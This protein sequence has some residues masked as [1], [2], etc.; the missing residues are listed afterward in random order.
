M[1]NNKI[2]DCITFFDNKLMFDLRF[3]ILKDHVDF[4]VVCE[5]KYDHRNNSKKLNFDLKFLKNNKVKYVVLDKPFPNENDIWKNQAIQREFL[6]NSLDS[7]VRENDFVF[8]SDPDEIPNPSLLINFNLKKKYGI[9]FQDCFNFKFNLYNPYETPW[10]GTRV[11]Q[12]KKPKV[13]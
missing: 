11:S 6:F 9:F 10:E 8:F 13:H 2:I 1:N 4:F 12:K 3:N 7:F 5:S